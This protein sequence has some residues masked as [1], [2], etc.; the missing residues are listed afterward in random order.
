MI[1]TTNAHPPLPGQGQASAAAA[2]STHRITLCACYAFAS[3]GNARQH[4]PHVISTRPCATIT[5][6][7]RDRGLGSEHTDHSPTDINAAPAMAPAP[8]VMGTSNPAASPHHHPA[9][10]PGADCKPT[11]TPT[12]NRI[13]K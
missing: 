4:K 5:H 1:T 6:E 3:T 9:V 13:K 12:L 7:T 2:T 10:L 11:T 8:I